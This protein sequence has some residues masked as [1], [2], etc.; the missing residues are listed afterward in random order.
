MGENPGVDAMQLPNVHP[1]T[2]AA[3]DGSAWGWFR[4]AHVPAEY[5]A[6]PWQW[7]LDWVADSLEGL[8]GA[9]VLPLPG[10]KP[11]KDERRWQLAKCLTGKHRNLLHNPIDGLDLRRIAA[12]VLGQM[13]E[14]AILQYQ[15]GLGHQ[16]AIFSRNEIAGLI[17][18]LDEGEILAEDRMLHRPYPGPDRQPTSSLVIELY[19]D[20]TLRTLVEQTYTNALLIYRDLTT[21]WFPAVVPT[22]GLASFMPI[23]MSGQLLHNKNP[24]PHGIPRFT[25]RM[26]PLPMTESPRAEVCL[27]TEPEDFHGF[28]PQEVRERFLLLRRQVA[29]LHPGAEGWALPPTVTT[30]VPLWHDRPATSL[31]YRWLWDDLRRLYLVKHLPPTGED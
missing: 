13:D 1:F 2:G 22:L 18:E 15:A 20:E 31:A 4:S 23:L 12:E 21:T 8:L 27:V 14:R 11:Y 29:R 10:S 3:P 19:S 7:G 17:R 24:S 25:F 26:T 28:D 16:A 9:K 30:S 5:M 6:W